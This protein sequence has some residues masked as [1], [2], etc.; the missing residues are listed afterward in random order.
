MKKSTGALTVALFIILSGCSSE[1]AKRSAFEA[2]QNKA[3]M[4]CQQNPGSNCQEKQS[5]DDYQRNL[6]S[7][8]DPGK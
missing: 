4:D 1:I 7:R 5:Y 6:N 8:S 3:Q 2:M